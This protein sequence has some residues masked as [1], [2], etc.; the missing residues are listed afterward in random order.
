LDLRFQ[1]DMESIKGAV[2]IGGGRKHATWFY[3]WLSQQVDGQK[4][5]RDTNFVVMSIPWRLEHAGRVVTSSYLCDQ[6]SILGMVERLKGALIIGVNVQAVSLDVTLDF[7]NGDRVKAFSCYDPA[8]FASAYGLTVE[9]H[10]WLVKYGH[11]KRIPLRKKEGG[12][13]E[14]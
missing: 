8:I 6:E 7:S 1:A 11:V 14:V 9:D 13:N 3:L 10:L 2:V 4:V 12:I 5:T